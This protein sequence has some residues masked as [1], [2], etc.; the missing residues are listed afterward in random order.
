[1]LIFYGKRINDYANR[2][3]CWFRLWKF[4]Q[5]GWKVS[6]AMMK[7][8]DYYIYIDYS[9]N[10]IGYAIIN[11]NKLKELLP[12][13]LRFRHYRKAKNRKLYLK[14]INK[15][16]KR[17]NIKSYFLKMKMRET[18]NNLAIYSDILEFLKIHRNC[19]IMISVDNS[20]YNNFKKLVAIVDKVNTV[21][22]QESDLIESTPEY[23]I[24]LVLDNLLNIE[25]LKT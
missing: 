20:E 5:K 16:I 17:Q 6:G 8:F 4:E 19:A 15:F 18:K 11:N 25:R 3:L 2:E 1:M 24:N 23:K 10:L 12:K 22:R 21:V 7:Q 9:E 14:N 13:I